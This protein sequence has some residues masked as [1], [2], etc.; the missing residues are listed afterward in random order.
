M[1]IGEIIFMFLTEKYIL[2]CTQRCLEARSCRNELQLKENYRLKVNDRKK[3]KLACFQSVK[4]V[5][6][7]Y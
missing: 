7:L 6:F 2:C 5:Q 3:F 1:E 4:S